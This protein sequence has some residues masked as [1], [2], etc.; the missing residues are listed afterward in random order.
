MWRHHTCVCQSGSVS[1]YKIFT[2]QPKE[3]RDTLDLM[4]DPVLIYVLLYRLKKIKSYMFGVYKKL[5]TS[6]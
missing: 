6:H 5:S 2:G 3:K 1:V 4:S